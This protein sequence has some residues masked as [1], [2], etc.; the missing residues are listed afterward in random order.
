MDFDLSKRKLQSDL[1]ANASFGSSESDLSADFDQK[2]IQDI[3]FGESNCNK[4]SS[5]SS[6]PKTTAQKVEHVDD[7]E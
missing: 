6:E 7:I 2:K 4:D 3:L 5:N 1:D